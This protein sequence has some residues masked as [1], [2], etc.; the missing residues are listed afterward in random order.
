LTIYD[1]KTYNP[2]TRTR[3]HSDRTKNN[4]IGKDVAMSI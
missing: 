1:A 2:T 4:I 3:T